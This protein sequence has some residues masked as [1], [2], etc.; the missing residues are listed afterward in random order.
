MKF[1][2]TCTC[3]SITLITSD[4]STHIQPNRVRTKGIHVAI[5]LSCGTLVNICFMKK[6]KKLD[7]NKD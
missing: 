5:S 3:F 6:K 1:E 4:A 7:K 2:I